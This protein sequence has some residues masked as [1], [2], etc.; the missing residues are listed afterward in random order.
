L[1]GRASF[2]AAD[3]LREHESVEST[4][5][6][7]VGLIW[8]LYIPPALSASATIATIIYA[9]RVESRRTVAAVT[10]YSV[11]QRALEEYQT[12]VVEK[13]GERKAIAAHDEIIQERIDRDPPGREIIISDEANVLCR[14]DFTGRYFQSN[15]ETL[16]RAVNDIN[17]Q[18]IHDGFASL[19]DLFHLIGLSKTGVSDKLGWT[20]DRLLEVRFTSAL[21]EGTRPCMVLDY[22]VAPIN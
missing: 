3:I 10:A 7:K 11:A 16:R 15:M 20:S 6:E 2:K 12:K 14:D 17:K 9:N 8:K 21:A 13:F 22:S 5:K 1:V 4:T 18:I 19:T